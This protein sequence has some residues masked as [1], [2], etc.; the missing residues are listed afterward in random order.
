[1]CRAELH[2]FQMHGDPVQEFLR[3][4]EMKMRNINTVINWFER[5][6]MA[7]SKIIINIFKKTTLWQEVLQQAGRHGAEAVG[8]SSYLNHKAHPQ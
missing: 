7:Y 4:L 6:Q 5:E 8:K 2:N 1:M 3:V